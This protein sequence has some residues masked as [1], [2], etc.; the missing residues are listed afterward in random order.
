MQTPKHVKSKASTAS[1][2]KIYKSGSQS[3]QETEL[4]A[5]K[6]ELQDTLHRS[7]INQSGTFSHRSLSC[8]KAPLSRFND[9]DASVSLK[10][11]DGD[12]SYSGLMRCNNA[13]YCPCCITRQL[14]SK[15]EQLQDIENAWLSKENRS[16]IMVTYTLQH[17][18]DDD[19]QTLVKDLAKAKSKLPKNGSFKKLKEELSYFSSASALE[20][21]ISYENGLH[22]H[23]HDAWYLDSVPT[24]QQLYSLNEKLQ[25]IW[26][27]ALQ[28][29]GRDCNERGINIAFSFYDDNNRLLHHDTSKPIDPYYKDTLINS[30][31]CT[32]K[33]LSK[34]TKELTFSFT[35]ITNKKK[36]FSFFQLLLDQYNNFS[37]K[38]QELIYSFV[39]A[40]T[41][42]SR[43]Y[44]NP[45]LKKML[46]EHLIQQVNESDTQEQS[47]VSTQLD[48]EY[49]HE[50]STDIDYTFTKAQWRTIC[51][52]KERGTVVRMAI[53]SDNQSHFERKLTNLF[54]RMHD[55][56]I[57][58][59]YKI[60]DLSKREQTLKASTLD[61]IKEHQKIKQ[62]IK[63]DTLQ[64]YKHLFN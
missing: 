47:T 46:K 30:V 51:F 38:K 29:V 34:I 23:K 57:P 43:I 4:Q 27:N 52:N 32:S 14:M 35:K 54:D 13:H 50:P 39:L 58:T 36:N 24:V 41:G 31:G 5:L 22:P 3:N 7:I 33:Y 28:S 16:V 42:K 12:V 61:A 48:N 20:T 15:S 63:R 45:E 49:L 26:K 18:N 56:I 1:L 11:T 64:T 8:T 62:K 60:L 21:T 59:E 55:G 40:M 17:K 53:T 2:G 9:V 44:I 10:R 25:K 37:Q 19:Y 6:Y